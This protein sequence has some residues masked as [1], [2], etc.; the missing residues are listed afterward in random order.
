MKEKTAAKLDTRKMILA[1]LFAALTVV[2]SKLQIPFFITPITLQTLF[3]ITSG[4]FLGARYGALSQAV[5]LILGLCGLP[6]FA[7]GGGIMYVFKPSFGF[8]LGFVPAAAVAGII[9]Q[10]AKGFGGY[11]LAAAAASLVVY[12]CGVPY[13]YL[14]LKQVIHS[15]RG[16]AYALQYGCLIFLPGDAIKSVAA[17][18]IASKA[19]P[20]IAERR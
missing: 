12:L 10:R 4:L 16:W 19:A 13:M 14:I 17:A 1:A 7:G 3:V 20:L 15:D 11:L 9:A 18:L 5:F 2:G 6:V 8:A